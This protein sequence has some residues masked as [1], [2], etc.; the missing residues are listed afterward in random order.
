MAA[1]ETRR[2]ESSGPVLPEV[3]RG[4]ST[5]DAPQKSFSTELLKPCPNTLPQDALHEAW[6]TEAHLIPHRKQRD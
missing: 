6:V 4:S 5:N 2:L 3:G 1:Q